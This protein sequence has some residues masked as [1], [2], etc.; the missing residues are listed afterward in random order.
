MRRLLATWLQAIHA[1][2]QVSQ[3]RYAANAMLPTSRAARRRRQ[4]QRCL[5]VIVQ[6]SQLR[7]GKIPSMQMM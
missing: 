5:R 1:P 4:R 2:D 7:D 6:R 3:H